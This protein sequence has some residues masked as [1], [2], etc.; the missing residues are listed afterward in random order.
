MGFSSSI[1]TP[2]PS[3]SLKW[4]LGLQLGDRASLGSCSSVEPIYVPIRL[5]RLF[6][7]HF[8]CR[9]TFDFSSSIELK[10]GFYILV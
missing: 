5:L 7:N 2:W 3:N 8:V 4:L 1:E 10:K 6:E 9:A